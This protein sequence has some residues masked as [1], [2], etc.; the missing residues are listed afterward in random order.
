MQQ[1]LLSVS[2]VAFQPWTGCANHRWDENQPC[3]LVLHLPDLLKVE[4]NSELRADC[5][6]VL[7]HTVP[8]TLTLTMGYCRSLT[9]T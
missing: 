1:A 7:H 2:G 5:M 4:T 6:L 8:S 3:L 9:R